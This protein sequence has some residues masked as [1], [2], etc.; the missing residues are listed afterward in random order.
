MVVL[1]HYHFHLREEDLPLVLLRNPIHP[2][3]VSYLK[4]GDAPIDQIEPD[5]TAYR[6]K[7]EQPHKDP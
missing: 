7:N 2:P 5:A 4:E 6:S 3:D 1:T